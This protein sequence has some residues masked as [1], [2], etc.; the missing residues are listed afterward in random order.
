MS[1]GTNRKRRPVLHLCGGIGRAA[2]GGD[3]VGA[4]FGQRDGD[5][6]AQARYWR[7]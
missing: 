4:G 2:A 7:R 1:A 5:G 6:L 3:D